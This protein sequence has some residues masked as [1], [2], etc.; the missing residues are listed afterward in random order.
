MQ[1]SLLSQMLYLNLL[2][3]T[4]IQRTEKKSIKEIKVAAVLFCT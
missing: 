2:L 1:E 4:L 3:N